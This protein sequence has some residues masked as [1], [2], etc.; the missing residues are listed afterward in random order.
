[1]RSILTFI[2]FLITFNIYGQDLPNLKG[3][4]NDMTNKKEIACLYYYSNAYFLDDTEKF[5]SIKLL[6][7]KLCHKLENMK[8][9][10]YE[11]PFMYMSLAIDKNTKFAVVDSILNELKS[12]TL[13]KV[14]FKTDYSDTSGFF[15]MIP[16]E[17]NA[18]ADFLQKFTR[19]F[20]EKRD[21]FKCLEEKEQVEEIQEEF[22]PI[23]R[24]NPPPTPKNPQIYYPFEI[25]L[26]SS[27]DS[28]INGHRYFFI[29]KKSNHFFINDTKY[30]KSKFIKTLNEII[31]TNNYYFVFDMVEHNTYSD[32]L[33]LYELVY[34]SIFQKRQWF[35]EQELSNKENNTSKY[36]I[37][38]IER[39]AKTKFPFRTLTY[40]LSDKEYL[41]LKKNNR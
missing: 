1:M 17:N 32:Y 41:K 21:I 30:S 13:L 34:N 5:A 16:P 18:K 15:L 36:I 14:F 40:S 38:H 9:E 33:T 39:E 37:H 31:E 25:V 27:K 12:F 2:A 23:S 28:I 4:V 29:K 8:F 19:Y 26:N 10:E 24:I 7:E 3:M 20:P 22:I 35:I 6:D 11:R